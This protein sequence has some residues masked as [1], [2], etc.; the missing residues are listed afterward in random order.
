MY[1]TM[2]SA[3]LYIE[4]HYGVSK[5]QVNVEMKMDPEGWGGVVGVGWVGVVTMFFI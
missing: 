3:H 4:S 5:M 2:V 1:I